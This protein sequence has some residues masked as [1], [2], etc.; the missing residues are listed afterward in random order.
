MVAA[1]LP[2][3]TS[4]AQRE[5]IRIS[6]ADP[7]TYPFPAGAAIQSADQSGN[8]TLVAWGGTAPVADTGVRP[9]LWGAIVQGTAR[10]GEPVMLTG[11]MAHPTG[12]ASVLP[13]A[14][15]FVVL[16]NDMRPGNA[17]VYMQR[18]DLNGARIGE[19]E[20]FPA[21]TKLQSDAQVWLMRDSTGYDVIWSEAVAGDQPNYF[22]QHLDPSGS[23]SG[24]RQQLHSLNFDAERTYAGL[25]GIRIVVDDPIS[26]Y[27]AD[28][29]L[30]ERLIPA[31]RFAQ[32]HYLGSDTSL[33][34][35]RYEESGACYFEYYA[36]VFDASPLRRILVPPFEG[37]VRSAGAIVADSS[38]GYR[39]YFLAEERDQLSKLINLYATTL[40]GDGSFSEPARLWTVANGADYTG[41]SYTFATLYSAFRYSGGDDNGHRI[42]F[43][44]LFSQRGRAGNDHTSTTTSEY[45]IVLDGDGNLLPLDLTEGESFPGDRRTRPAVTRTVSPDSTI[46]RLSG[47]SEG[48]MLGMPLAPVAQNLPQTTPALALANGE[49]VALWRHPESRPRFHQAKFFSGSDNPVLPL[50]VFI[51]DSVASYNHGTRSH[52]NRAKINS[53]SGGGIVDYTGVDG[54]KHDM[55]G[56]AVYTFRS[57]I[58]T[59]SGW[60]RKSIGYEYTSVNEPLFDARYTYDPVTGN[61]LGSFT[62][63][64]N[65]KPQRR[66]IMFGPGGTILWDTA[67]VHPSLGSLIVTGERDYL[68][69]HDDVAFNPA[70]GQVFS[71]ESSRATRNARYQKALGN[72]FFRYYPADPLD[73]NGALTS[74]QVQF[75]QYDLQGNRTGSVRIDASGSSFDPTIIQRPA[76]FSLYVLW[77]SDSG[78]WL[79][80]I[81]AGMES[82]SRPQ[83]IS[84]TAGKV[85]SA[86]AV[87]RN[88]SLFIVWEDYRNGNPDIYGAAY[89]A[90]DFPSGV[91]S[92]PDDRG[93]QLGAYPVPA[94]RQVN[95]V[96]ET[97]YEGKGRIIVSDD[98]GQVMSSEYIAEVKGGVKMLTLDVSG[99]PPGAYFLTLVQDNGSSAI[100]RFMVRR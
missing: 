40:R 95:V 1:L 100:G 35:L 22:R 36:N 25:P 27:H 12:V 87:F 90:G 61:T 52:E 64:H 11:T 63:G 16:W 24:A 42:T 70:G 97:P 18:V 57:Y 74:A 71:F 69:I 53:F 43:N 2:Y 79:S 96:L 14:D 92:E 80:V 67:H 30:D 19:E 46:V 48:I 20:R 54:W 98:A 23:L 7:V 4:M 49:I 26:F 89:P 66:M 45:K 28:G 17:G 34:M 5:D 88:D 93:R 99:F 8:A 41:G 62:P 85:R 32:P 44:G 3:G 91:Q 68:N 84:A 13:L 56:A 50:P 73:A 39:I 82:A 75:E 81:S 86:A 9:V 59:D 38:G 58:P 76:D 6:P 33:A 10:Q 94:D 47:G 31:D 72:R 60:N 29:R 77:P 65:D 55:G 15:R 37:R 21:Q 83:R 78:L 51:P